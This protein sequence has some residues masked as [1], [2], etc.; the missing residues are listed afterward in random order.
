MD[1]LKDEIKSLNKR[2]ESIITHPIIQKRGELF[3]N[4]W[5]HSRILGIVP[6]LTCPKCG[7]SAENIVWKC[8]DL[9]ILEATELAHKKYQEALDDKEDKKAL[10]KF[11]GEIGRSE[12]E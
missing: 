9:T 7:A 8:H 5:N 6:A 3:R 10:D 12:D 11:K 4:W 1:N 2:F